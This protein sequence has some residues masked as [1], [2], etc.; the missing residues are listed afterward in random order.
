MSP[1]LFSIIIN[2]LCKVIK[3]AKSLLFADDL[4]ISDDVSTPECREFLKQ[5]VGAVYD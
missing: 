5:D 2:G 4:K 3:H 1:T